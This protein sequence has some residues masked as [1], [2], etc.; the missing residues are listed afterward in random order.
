ME[1]THKVPD[2]EESRTLATLVG[3]PTLV[4]VSWDLG[5]H[6]GRPEGLHRPDPRRPRT[7][8]RDPETR[9]LLLS[10]RGTPTTLPEGP[11]LRGSR[12]TG[13]GI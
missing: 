9:R 6:P 10:W 1:N 3:V 4:V 12:P 2:F 7:K 13:L 8:W 11:P 5:L